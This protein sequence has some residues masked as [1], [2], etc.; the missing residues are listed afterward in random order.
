MDV[1]LDLPFDINKVHDF[2]SSSRIFWAKTASRP[3]DNEFNEFGISVPQHSID[4]ASV[5]NTCAYHFLD[6][7]SLKRI[8]EVSPISVSKLLVLLALVHDV[9][10]I[11][12]QF[13]FKVPTACSPEVLQYPH[14][15]AGVDT[16]YKK[17]PHN[18]IGALAFVDWLE[19]YETCSW[20]SR[21]FW[22]QC[23]S[24]HHGA[25]PE[26]SDVLYLRDYFSKPNEETFAWYEARRVYLNEVKD[27]LEL[28]DA[29]LVQLACFT[30]KTACTSLIEGLLICA[31]WIGSS[32]VFCNHIHHEPLS[33]KAQKQRIAKAYENISLGNLWHPQR[34]T[35]ADV[36]RRAQLPPY[37][38]LTWVQQ[39]SLK[40]AQ[41]V[42]GSS[43]YLIEDECGNGK[44]EAALSLAENIAHTLSLQGIFFAQPTRITSDAMFSRVLSWIKAGLQSEDSSSMQHSSVVS[45]VLAHGKASFNREFESLIPASPIYDDT[46][47]NAKGLA[48]LDWF[49]G[50][51]T[52][53]LAHITVGTIDQLLFMALKSRHL[54]MRH[55]GLASKV[56]IIDELHASD[57]WMRV[58]LYRALEWLGAYG[59]PVIGLSATLPPDIRSKLL[60]AY[61]KG[62]DSLRPE[63][64]ETTS[65]P[66]ISA[67]N[68]D[69]GLKLFSPDEQTSSR[70]ISRSVQVNFVGGQL[71]DVAR[72]I[73]K[74][75]EDC[76]DCAPV[77]GVVCDTV[78]R[79]QSLFMQL[80]D[81]Y[82][83][84]GASSAPEL[85]LLH[86]RFCTD[87][88]SQ[89]EEHLV[90]AFGKHP[91]GPCAGAYRSKEFKHGCIVVSTQI[92]EQGLD[93]DFDVLFS[94]IAPLDLLIQRIGRLQRHASNDAYRPSSLRVPTVHI[95]GVED[96]EDVPH[97]I[98]RGAVS[99]YKKKPL[100]GSYLTLTQH[101]NK[102]GALH[103]PKDVSP[104][105][106]TA[107]AQKFSV[108]KAYETEFSK[109]QKCYNEFITKQEM[110]AYTF[111]LPTT[112]GSLYDWNNLEGIALEERSYSKVRDIDEALEVIVCYRP[113]VDSLYAISVQE[114]LT[115]IN[116][117]SISQFDGYLDRAL[118]ACTLRLPVRFSHDSV[119][120]ELEKK[121]YE[122]LGTDGWNTWQESPWLRGQLLLTLDERM[123][124]ELDNSLL[125][126]NSKIGLAIKA[127]ED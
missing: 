9:G 72:F 58:Y 4:V 125:T 24:G 53:L 81:Y 23:I 49:R 101:V 29:D 86:S 42:K 20:K 109:A 28:T 19:T 44:T 74:Q 73:L 10:K 62:C 105:I 88:R 5:I 37:A 16:T 104:L 56:V 69:D 12:W 78:G 65:Y 68:P 107:F 11:S 97:S 118:A 1:Q 32:D 41:E 66:L 91:Q 85:I 25:F 126:Y 113:T 75:L 83:H 94:D 8:Q 71:D 87:L 116:L 127:L 96:L 112:K 99:V 6:A 30:P 67:Y 98:N 52:S 33:T 61:A 48:A 103:I 115:D 34:V 35:A 36:V 110:N 55:L 2:A 122:T 51:K 18:I 95:F 121:T 47:D 114:E 84:M 38:Q 31:D 111:C 64:P 92:I 27:L 63:V 59:V 45:T 7:Q 77:V 22:L 108:P 124:A 80:N 57:A 93:I 120:E 17:A 106:N 15:F 79:A 43:F 70:A 50:P 82:A 119:I 3:S 100:L 21:K 123:A 76:T 60:G 39:A 26:E 117:Y 54:A 14:E 89:R 90:H 102:H 13:Q 40:L 46:K